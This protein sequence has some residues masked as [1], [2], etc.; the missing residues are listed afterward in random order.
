M[1][2]F[3]STWVFNCSTGVL[4]LEHPWSEEQAMG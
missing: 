4:L 2:L 1:K 3:I